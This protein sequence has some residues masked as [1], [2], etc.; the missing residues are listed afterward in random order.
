VD[1]DGYVKPVAYE[2]NDDVQL[3]GYEL[4]WMLD[5]VPEEE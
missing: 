2:F 3:F 4:D 5:E 1:D